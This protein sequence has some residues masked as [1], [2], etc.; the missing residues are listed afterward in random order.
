ML[1]VWPAYQSGPSEEETEFLR[2]QFGYRIAQASKNDERSDFLDL[3][4]GNGKQS[5]LFMYV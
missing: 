5:E 4:Q 1:L 3:I 2:E